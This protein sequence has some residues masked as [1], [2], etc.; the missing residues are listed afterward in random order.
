MASELQKKLLEMFECFHK[1]TKE[2][3]LRY[4]IV[5][6]T[7]LGATR[8][9]GFIPWDNDIDV[10]MPRESYNKLAKLLNVKK[11]KYI[12]ESLNYCSNDYYAYAKLY[13]TSTTLTEFCKDYIII[14][15]NY[16]LLKK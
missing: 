11:D 14:L 1:Y 6:E 10:E 4:Y 13:D 7:L 9:Q 15:R 3:A 5:D 16:H 8:H 2:N 12:M